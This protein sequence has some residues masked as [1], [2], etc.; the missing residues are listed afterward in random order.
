MP[1]QPKPLTPI[2]NLSIIQNNLLMVEN[3]ARMVA[4]L[5]GVQLTNLNPILLNMAKASDNLGIWMIKELKI[6][7]SQP[8]NRTQKRRIE[9][10]AHK[11]A[12]RKK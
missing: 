5:H 4:E 2:Q 7:P 6:N 3:W 8:M 10:E 12:Q 1:Q 11:L 9:R